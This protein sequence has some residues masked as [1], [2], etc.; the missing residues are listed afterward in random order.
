MTDCQGFHLT[1]PLSRYRTQYSLRSSLR[2]E[3]SAKTTTACR[4]IILIPHRINQTFTVCLNTT[5][6]APL[7]RQL[8]QF[9]CSTPAITISHILVFKDML[10]IE[11]GTFRC[12]VEVNYSLSHQLAN[13]FSRD[14]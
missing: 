8:S 5:I 2:L 4:L 11:P 6:E 14:V 12:S 7:L 9:I 1:Q 3:F 10:S 13:V